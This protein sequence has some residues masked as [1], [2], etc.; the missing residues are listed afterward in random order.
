MKKSLKKI[1]LLIFTVI[2]LKNV[3]TPVLAETEILSGEECF[4]ENDIFENK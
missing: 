1:S 4:F 2:L 3:Y